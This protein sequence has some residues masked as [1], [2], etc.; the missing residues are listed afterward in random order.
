MYRSVGEG[1]CLLF[2]LQS[3]SVST[4]LHPVTRV[5]AF[6]A[7]EEPD[8]AKV[9]NPSPESPATARV[10]R[11]ATEMRSDRSSKFTQCNNLLKQSN[12]C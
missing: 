9:L 10:N 8:P 6:L 2:S 3:P 4:V 11:R 12:R 5:F 7:T 1:K